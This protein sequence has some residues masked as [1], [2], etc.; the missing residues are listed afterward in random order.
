[1]M[2]TTH[3]ELPMDGAVA[4]ATA[5]PR[6]VRKRAAS[7]RAVRPHPVG[8]P[9]S[10]PRVCPRAAPVSTFDFGYLAGG[11]PSAGSASFRRNAMSSR[12]TRL[13]CDTSSRGNQR[14]SSLEPSTSLRSAPPTTLAR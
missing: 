2:D 13:S 8:T 1:M 6:G 9:A 4:P 10:G 5:S 7:S 14:A 12:L 3:T 11:R